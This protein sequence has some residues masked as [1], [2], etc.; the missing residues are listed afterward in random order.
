MPKE[1]IR[2]GVSA[3]LLG[4]RVRYNG[5]HQRDAI[6]TK[7]LAPFIEWVP[8]C[9]EIEIGLGVPRPVMRLTGRSASP[10]LVV[11]STGEDLTARMRRYARAK[12]AELARLELDGF[13]LKSR[14]PSCGLAGVPVQDGRRRRPGRGLWAA[15]L[16]RRV[17]GLPV[18][19]ET[20]LADPA[21]RARFLSRARQRAARRQSRRT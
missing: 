6:V 9:P 2:L 18:V 20:D 7:L 10:R 19:E 13:V 1:K 12:A 5:G 21:I 8:V 14:S 4:E 11:E 17:R 15:A 16:M 3:C